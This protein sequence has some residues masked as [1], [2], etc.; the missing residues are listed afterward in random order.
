V[1]IVHEIEI[2]PWNSNFETGIPE[3]DQQHQ[4]LV[5]LLNVL[6]KHLAYQADAPS[7]DTVLTELKDYT[8]YHFSTEEA[9]W[10]KAFNGDGWLQWHKDSHG[11]FVDKIQQM[12]TDSQGKDYDEAVEQIVT[13]LTH[14][15]ALHIIESDKR[16][17]KV[18]LALS[19]GLSLEKAKELANKEMSGST[20]L[21]IETV[22]GM[23]DSLAHR[24]IQLTR[25]IN[26][27]QKTETALRQAQD[28]LTRLKDQAVEGERQSRDELHDF[29]NI[30]AHH[31]KEPVRHQHIFASQLRK[32][33]TSKGL[34]DE[35][36]LYALDRVTHGADR[37]SCLLRDSLLQLSVAETPRKTSPHS[38]ADDLQEA[39]KRLGKIIQANN[40]TVVSN[41]MPEAVLDHK[42]M[43]DTLTALISNAISFRR[44]D[45]AP[46]IHVCGEDRGDKYFFSVEDNGI[47]IPEEFRERVFRVFERLDPDHS[48]DGTGVGLSVVRKMVLAAGGRIWIEGSV[49]G[50]SVISFEI[51][52]SRLG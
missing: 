17:A 15:L 13:F 31:L 19:S 16:M 2:F 33:L 50:G 44:S 43:T 18:A 12:L 35:D 6:V 34:L 26:A 4:R 14:W 24:T 46:I 10:E 39:L 29:A 22:M 30:M 38:T 41:A 1:S 25:E 36:T 28:E 47:G 42:R 27:R 3:I 51:P 8:V 52:K 11:E 7:I 21:L 32:L 5:G 45:T 37:L 40:A 20:R 49:S 9:I 48:T 23:Y